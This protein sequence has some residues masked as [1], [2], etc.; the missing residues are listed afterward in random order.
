MNKQP[1]WWWLATWFGCGSSPMVSGTVGSLAALP[2]GF[3]IHY[4]GGNMALFVASIFTFLIGC[5]AADQ[6]VRQGGKG[7]DPKDIVI[8]EVAGQWLLLSVLFPTW[9]SYLVGFLLFR[10]FDIAKPWPIYVID[11]KIKGGL[12]VML[13]DMAAAFYPIGVYMI[14]LLMTAVSNSHDVLAP[15]M[16][17]LGG[18]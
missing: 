10:L 6:F 2:V 8:D 18:M 3:I 9:Q 13:D 7:E 5:W 16:R 1:L 12:G 4:Y 15:V 11:R 17:F 14:I